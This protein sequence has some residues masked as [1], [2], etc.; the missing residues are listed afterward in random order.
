MVI[1]DLKRL[2]VAQAAIV[3]DDLDED[4][5]ETVW[6][7]AEPGVRRFVDLLTEAPGNDGMSGSETEVVQHRGSEIFVAKVLRSR[8]CGMASRERESRS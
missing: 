3:E 5:E 4:L 6:V 1:N 2:A 8:R 7:F